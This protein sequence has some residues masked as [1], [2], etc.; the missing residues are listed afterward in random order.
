MDLIEKLN[1][2]TKIWILQKQFDSLKELYSLNYSIK[3]KSMCQS[4]SHIKTPLQKS[5]KLSE[6]IYLLI[7]NENSRQ[8]Y[9]DS[10]FAREKY[11]LNSIKEEIEKTANQIDQKFG[12][13]KI[14]EKMRQNI[15]EKRWDNKHL[16]GLESRVENNVLVEARRC[17][18]CGGRQVFIEGRNLE[19]DKREVCPTCLQNFFEDLG[20]RMVEERQFDEDAQEEGQTNSVVDEEF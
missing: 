6:L 17:R 2:I 20:E 7:L 3:N 18:K 8:E 16:C 13:D 11:D 4:K 9:Y 1:R 10:E 12:E 15:D 5:K 14:I 19:S